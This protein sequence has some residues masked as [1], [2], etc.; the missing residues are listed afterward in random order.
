MEYGNNCISEPHFDVP[1]HIKQSHAGQYLN[2]VFTLVGWIPGLHMTDL[3]ALSVITV[4]CHAKIVLVPPGTCNF[5]NQN[6]T[7]RYTILVAK[8]VPALPKVYRVVRKNR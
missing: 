8:S 7:E 4:T 2:C 1:I 3:W 5:R 6:C